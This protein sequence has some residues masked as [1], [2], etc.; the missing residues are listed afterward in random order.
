MIKWNRWHSLRREKKVYYLLNKPRRVVSTTDDDKNRK[1]VIDLIDTD[2]R[3][4]P[5]G[6]LDYDTGLILLANDGELSNII[7]SSKNNIEKTYIAKIEVLLL[8]NEFMS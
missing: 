4:F 7:T 1:T 3:I 2:K 8:P 5:V 6:R